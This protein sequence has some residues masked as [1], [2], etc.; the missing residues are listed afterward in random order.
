M[1]KV[2]VIMPGDIEVAEKVI[3]ASRIKTEIES[4]EKAIENTID[5]LRQLR[6]SAGKKIGTPV[7]KIFDAQLLIAGDN[8]FLKLVKKEITIKKRNAGFIYYNLVKN[9]TIPL[10]R[11]PDSYMRQMATDIEAVADK[12][13]THL[14]G[15]EKCD[16]KFPPNT[17]LTGKMFTPGD[18]L[19]YRQR[20]AIGF[21]VSEGGRNSHM[22]L[23]SRALMIPVVLIKNSYL[24]IPNY[25]RLIID[26]T[27]GTII[28]NPADEDWLEYQRL[29][30]RQGPAIISR[31]KQLTQVPPLTADGKEINVGANLTLPGPVDD[32][33]TLHNFP[34]G[35]YRTEF[36]HLANNQFPDEQTQFEYYSAIAEKYKNSSVVLRTFDLGYDK[37]TENSDWP[38]EDNPALGWRGIRAMLEMQHLFKTQIRA[39]LRA[40]NRKN[41]KIML[42]MISDVTELEKAKKLI[43]QVKFTLHKEKISFDENIKVGI[44]VEVPSAA[45]TT[46]TLAKKVD[47]VSIGTN[48]LT[49]YTLAADRMNNKVANL[50]S[51]F[52]P[53]VI[54]LIW[55]TVQA[56]KKL[57]IPVSICGEAAG[58]L[59]ALPLFIGMDINLLSM[60]PNRIFDLCR[61]V[62]KI[63]SVMA[64]HLLNSIL[65]CDS[66]QNVL[67]IL[68]NYKL[69][70]EK[71]KP[72]SRRK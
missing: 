11:S 41:I 71:K 42:P 51:S 5:D 69:E 9:N 4:L 56:C 18:I 19:S 27:E 38:Q 58:D 61:L 33:L 54:K 20:K 26:G 67:N 52:H 35:L 62:K 6:E 60:S 21:V 48:D 65:A 29:K 3:P 31:I 34:I 36:L 64:Q 45:L 66:Q 14:G 43:S 2:R 10:K 32:I 46:E 1:G 53:S 44:M 59:L 12:V 50:Y 22:A 17:I 70:L 57:N 63:D 23:I 47:F 15:Y 8:E 25:S 16:I 30:K 13:L 7:A 55:V 40:S 68:Q 28:I 37:L 72:L 49:Q 24:S 39:I